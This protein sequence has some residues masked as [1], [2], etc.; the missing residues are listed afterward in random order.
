[1]VG[2]DCRFPASLVRETPQKPVERGRAFA[3]AAP[4]CASRH[5]ALERGNKVTA[6]GFAIRP[7]GG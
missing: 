3:C 6:M 2:R 4:V 5:F 7:E 1:M